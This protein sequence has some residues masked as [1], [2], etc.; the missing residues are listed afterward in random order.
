MKK[1]NRKTLMIVSA[2]LLPVAAAA[3][4]IPRLFCR[5]RQNIWRRAS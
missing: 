4:A 5:S 3:I 1:P 2:I